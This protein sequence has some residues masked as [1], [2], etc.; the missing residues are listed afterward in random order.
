MASPACKPRW[1]ST[2]HSTMRPRRSC[3][4]R[5]GADMS[6]ILDA[7]KKS[8]S[9]RQRQAS[10][11]LVEV[12]VAAPRR[13]FPGWAAALG[14]LLGV[15]VLALGWVLLRRQDAAPPAAAV[16][17][18]PTAQASA[19]TANGMQ[20]GTVMVPATVM[21]PT[22]VQ[23]PVSAAPSVT[24]AQAAPQPGVIGPGS[25]PPLAAEPRLENQEQAVPPDYDSR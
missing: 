17:P 1:R 3:A 13:R 22:Q 25:T 2:R 21:L 15:N 10:P 11:A 12:K 24:V 8:E 20:P 9:D 16:A 5:P 7:L 23:I 6:F 14:V 18:S 4:T 19:A